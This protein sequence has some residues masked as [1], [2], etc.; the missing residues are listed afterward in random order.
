MAENRFVTPKGDLRDF[1]L[2][3]AFAVWASI[4][5]ENPSFD[6]DSVI[7]VIPCTLYIIEGSTEYGIHGTRIHE[8]H[9]M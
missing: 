4:Y 2:I 6:L 1:P 7:N 3:S 8:P 9:Y 5:V